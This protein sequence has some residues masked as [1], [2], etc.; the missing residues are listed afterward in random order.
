M[1][2]RGYM[3]NSQAEPGVKTIWLALQR[4]MDFAA[5]SKFTKEAHGL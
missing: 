1:S 3:V 2:G 5:G 4:V